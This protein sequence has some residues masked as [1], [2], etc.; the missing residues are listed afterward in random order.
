MFPIK[1]T[2]FLYLASQSHRRSHRGHKHFLL[3]VRLRA[4]DREIEEC[5]VGIGGCIAGRGSCGEE[6]VRR[7]ELGVDLNAD[8][9]FPVLQPGVSGCLLG[10]PFCC[11]GVFFL[12]ALL[13]CGIFQGFAEGGAGVVGRGGDL[14]ARLEGAVKGGH[15][16]GFMSQWLAGCASQT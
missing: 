8:G 2:P 7:V 16:Q 4:R 3:K 1:S 9:E 14:G 10:G 6:F 11:L 12:F 5:D 15:N 13:L